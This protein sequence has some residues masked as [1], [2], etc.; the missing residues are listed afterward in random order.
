MY[1]PLITTKH[2]ARPHLRALGS[3]LRWQPYPTCTI[4]NPKWECGDPH[5][6]GH[7][8]SFQP[9]NTGT[10]DSTH[11]TY[12]PGFVCR[13]SF[14]FL[15]WKKKKYRSGKKIPNNWKQNLQ[16]VMQIQQ[17]DVSSLQQMS[18]SHIHHHPW[19][20]QHPDEFTLSPLFIIGFGII[21]W[22]EE[23][24]F[25]PK[26][27]LLTPCCGTGKGKIK[28][29]LYGGWSLWRWR[30][31]WCWQVQR[32]WHHNWSTLRGSLFLIWGT[33]SAYQTTGERSWF[34][35]PIAH[36]FGETLMLFVLFNPSNRRESWVY[37]PY[38]SANCST[39]TYMKR[40][41]IFSGNKAT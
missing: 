33:N 21:Q 11:L 22:G 1:F 28:R 14:F 37:L 23:A 2:H 26:P 19:L 13:R 30:L 31:E 24:G 5:K 6:N 39:P 36:N 17:Q 38:L 3:A 18:L 8:A 41:S 10:G 35:D 34:T 40:L 15:F 25:E 4:L 20:S 32:S 12:D 7:I 16:I 27:E 29:E 9:E